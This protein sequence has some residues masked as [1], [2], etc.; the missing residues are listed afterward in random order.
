MSI[1]RVFPFARGFVTFPRLLF[2]RLPSA[3]RSSLPHFLT[4]CLLRS[5][6]PARPIIF[7]FPFLPDWQRP[8]GEGTR[9]EGSRDC[10]TFFS[11]KR[12]AV[13]GGVFGRWRPLLRGKYWNPTDNNYKK[14]L[15]L[16]VNSWQLELVLCLSSRP[17]SFVIILLAAQ[18]GVS[19]WESYD[20]C[21]CFEVFQKLFWQWA[22]WHFDL[23]TSTAWVLFQQSYRNQYVE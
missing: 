13:V 15:S 3:R 1:V 20:Y 9:E 19:C 2:W 4:P 10:W 18:Y 14:V 16:S 11:P 8:C 12:G 17:E 22:V 7:L 23:T 6:P 5:H 21:L